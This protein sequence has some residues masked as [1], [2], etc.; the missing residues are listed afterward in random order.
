M[1]DLWRRNYIRESSQPLVPQRT[2]RAAVLTP[3]TGIRVILF[4]VYGTLLISASG[5]IG[6]ESAMPHGRD[7][8]SALQAVG[9]SGAGPTSAEFQAEIRRRQDAARRCGVDV[10]EIE[11]RDVW[12][13]LLAPFGMTDPDQVADL[14]VAYEMQ[15]NPIWPMP[16]FPEVLDGLKKQFRLG[17]VSNAQFYTP[18]VLEA[19]TGRSWADL[20]FEDALCAWSYR[21]HRAKPSPGLWQPILDRLRADGI[22][23]SQVVMVGNDE[24]KDVAPAHALGL[25]TVLFAGDQRSL[26]VHPDESHGP[27]S[28]IITDLR[29]LPQVL[30]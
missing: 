14:A 11:V 22:H 9:W 21:S 13:T 1:T 25:H 6:V 29:Q 16:G 19:L 5:D 4:D 2:N 10:P 23:P 30:I 20:G 24:R 27:P 17:V 28:A 8:A 12:A 15:V 18:L 7:T 3:L 26:R